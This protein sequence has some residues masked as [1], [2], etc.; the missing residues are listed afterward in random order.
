MQVGNSGGPITSTSPGSAGAKSKKDDDTDAPKKRSTVKQ[1]VVSVAPPS[2]TTTM[3]STAT[4]VVDAGRKARS[5][6][7]ALSMAPAKDPGPQLKSSTGLAVDV[8]P[9]TLAAPGLQKPVAARMTAVTKPLAQS[10]VSGLLPFVTLAPAADGN[11]RGSTESPLLLGFMA[12]G[13]EVDRKASVEDESLARTVDST[14][15][16]LMT[17]ATNSL[18]SFQVKAT[19]TSTN[20][21]ITQPTVSLDRADQRRVGVGHGDPDRHRF[22]QCQGGR[23][24]VL[25]RRALRW[26]P[27]TPSRPIARRGTPPRSP[28]APIR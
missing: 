26:A 17:T 28:M 19:R 13:R 16:S 21:D 11:Q 27:R 9:L 8:A 2:T 5:L 12:G 15:T 14:E 25:C 10:P 7:P 6:S 1:K 24:A 23:G 20:R 4:T 22:G 3:Q 18:T